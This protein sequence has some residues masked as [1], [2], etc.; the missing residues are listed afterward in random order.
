MLFVV[1]CVCACRILCQDHSHTLNAYGFETFVVKSR[2]DRRYCR[3]IPDSREKDSEHIWVRQER[4][5]EIGDIVEAP[6]IFE[7]SPAFS[8]DFKGLPM[9]KPKCLPLQSTKLHL[10]AIFD[11][12]ALR[13]QHGQKRLA[14]MSL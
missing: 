4:V 11:L 10:E 12:P 13:N 6:R 7:Q 3:G 5:D 9:L 2:R 14:K 1:V 8:I